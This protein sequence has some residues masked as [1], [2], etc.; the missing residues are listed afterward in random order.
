MLLN[1]EANIV[2]GR[3]TGE[4]CIVNIENS[5][6]YL[7]VICRIG[8][9]SVD[10]QI[11]K[12]MLTTDLNATYNDFVPYTGDGETLTHDVAELKNDLAELDEVL[13]WSNSSST[14]VGS[15]ITLNDSY[16]NYKYIQIE[17][18]PSFSG[19]MGLDIIKKRVFGDI[20]YIAIKGDNGYKRTITI[21]NSDPL[22]WKVSN[23]TDGDSNTNDLIPKYIY[24][25]KN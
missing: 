25:I 12:P 14:S 24:G 9:I 4:G 6:Y 17:Y 22:N 11:F 7:M 13:L 8:N 1:V 20:N 18:I 16:K 2:Y 15:T 5:G 21:S 10:N 3:D 19:G 23:C